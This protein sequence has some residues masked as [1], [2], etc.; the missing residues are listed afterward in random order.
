MILDRGMAI[1]RK[2][3]GRLKSSHNDFT[4]IGSDILRPDR[5]LPESGFGAGRQTGKRN[6][7][8]PHQLAQFRIEPF[9]MKD[10]VYKKGAILIKILFVVHREI[11]LADII[12][13]Q[14]N[15]RLHP[16]GLLGRKPAAVLCATNSLGRSLLLYR[17]ILDRG[18]T[19]P[20]ADILTSV[21]QSAVLERS[22]AVAADVRPMW[23]VR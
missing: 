7:Q 2:G 12:V 11:T 23:T 6:A 5:V 19:A 18:E 13:P 21:R 10:P 4:L 15:Q 8:F 1:A 3:K 20:D 14:C 9:V 22:A 16:F 17:F